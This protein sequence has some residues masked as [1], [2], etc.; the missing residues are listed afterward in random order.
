MY[1]LKTA[2]S[3]KLIFFKIAFS[4]LL[5]Q[6][7]KNKFLGYIFKIP[8]SKHTFSKNYSLKNTFLKIPFPKKT[9]SKLL[10]QKILIYSSSES[11]ESSEEPSHSSI[12]Y[13]ITFFLM[14][15]HSFKNS[16]G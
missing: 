1:F 10:S 4:K 3:K 2:P 12:I 5:S 16:C 7:I 9:F 8:Y 11:S 15:L 14:Y 6:I 13:L